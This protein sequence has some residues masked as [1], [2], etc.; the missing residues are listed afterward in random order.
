MK[1]IL[2]LITFTA[3]I[4]LI[5]LTG[6]LLEFPLLSLQI[7]SVL[8]LFSSFWLIKR[9]GKLAWPYLLVMDL[10]LLILL[11]V[12]HTSREFFTYF[13]YNSEWTE[14]LIIAG[15]FAISQTVGIFWGGRFYSDNHK[16]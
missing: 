1:R 7:I 3:A 13:R 9:D 8:L 16:K 10:M 5:V 15:L 12:L 6:K 11:L 4:W 2:F 14:I